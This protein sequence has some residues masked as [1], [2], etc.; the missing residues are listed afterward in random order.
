MSIREER[1]VLY[2][3]DRGIEVDER[4]VDLTTCWD[5]KGRECRMV[6]RSGFIEVLNHQRRRVGDETDDDRQGEQ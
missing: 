2:C 1:W 4:D 6:D 3:D 5:T